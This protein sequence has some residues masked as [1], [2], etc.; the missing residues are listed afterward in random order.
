MPAPDHPGWHE[1]GISDSERFNPQVMGRM[2]IR[3]EG[4]KSGRLRVLETCKLH[5]NLHGNI[6]GAVTLSLVD[7][8]LFAAAYVV[9]GP[10]RAGSVTLDLN[11]Q[12][13]GSG[14]IGKPLD[15]VSEIM[16]E[17]G[18]LIFMRGVVEQDGELIASYMGTLRKPSRK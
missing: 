5:S 9:L 7:I 4:E 3:R 16:R 2:L 15:A 6:H 17:T 12:F 13:T 10:D 1:W 8:G 18:R 11:C 14:K